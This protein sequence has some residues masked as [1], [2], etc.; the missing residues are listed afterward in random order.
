M[1]EDSMAELQVRVEIQDADGKVQKRLTVA[2]PDDIRRDEFISG[3]RSRIPANMQ[4]DQLDIYAQWTQA[5]TL[6]TNNS[7]VII[8]PRST[9]MRILEER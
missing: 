1:G 7:L 2:V 6:L 5:N 8:K 3:L 9:E 4:N